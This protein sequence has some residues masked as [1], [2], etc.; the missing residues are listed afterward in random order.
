MQAAQVDGKLLTKKHETSPFSSINSC[1][2]GLYFSLVKSD[3]SHQ[4][5]FGKCLEIFCLVKDFLPSACL[6]MEHV[7][8]H[9]MG[10][11]RPLMV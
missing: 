3:L 11:Q 7:Y 5:I 8:M 6:A 2:A 4:G 1:S 9:K 10:I